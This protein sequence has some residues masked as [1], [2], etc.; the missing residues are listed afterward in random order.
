MSKAKLYNIS[1]DVDTLRDAIK[2]KHSSLYTSPQND[3]QYL[4]CQVWINEEISQY[5]T[6]GNMNLKP[7][8]DSDEKAIKIGNIKPVD[9]TKK[10]IEV[11]DDLPPLGESG[12]GLPF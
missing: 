5:G 4:S 7:G 1:I 10:E 2:S 11:K 9:F 3:K 8:K 6:I 12:D